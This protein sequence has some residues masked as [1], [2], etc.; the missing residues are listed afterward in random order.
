MI[1]QTITFFSE[2]TPIS[3][4]SGLGTPTYS[5]GGNWP[6]SRT[7]FAGLEEN[8]KQ[9]TSTLMNKW[10]D[11]GL[12]STPWLTSPLNRQ[13]KLG[14]TTQTN[15]H[16]YIWLLRRKQFKTYWSLQEGEDEKHFQRT[17]L[18]VGQAWEGLVNHLILCPFQIACVRWV[19]DHLFCWSTNLFWK[20]HQKV[21]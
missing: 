13:A 14:W 18:S 3:F 4:R 2:S 10:G 17:S 7:V 5:K 6:L 12:Q 19:H 20:I 15:S 11:E 16:H 8:A 21:K 1:L 9:K